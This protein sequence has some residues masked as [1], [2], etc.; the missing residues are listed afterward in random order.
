MGKRKTGSE[1]SSQIERQPRVLLKK[2]DEQCDFL[3]NN[4]AKFDQGDRHYAYQA[5][6]N[7]RAL[8]SPREPLPSFFIE[9]AKGLG[10]I[11]E[12]EGQPGGR[13]DPQNP[14]AP[15]FYMSSP[16]APGSV[17]PGSPFRKTVSFDEWW[18]ELILLMNVKGRPMQYLRGELILDAAQYDGVHIKSKVSEKFATLADENA[19]K[20]VQSGSSA[21]NVVQSVVVESGRQLLKV[22]S[23]SRGKM[24]SAVV[25][26]ELGEQPPGSR[27]AACP[28]GSGKRFKRCHGHLL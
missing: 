16:L 20:L 21:L 1:Y 13:I 17:S 12:F 9:I 2:L 8:V 5:A 11:T 6:G 22:I 10:V 15:M 26:Q 23:A 18:G 4:I 19:L 28:C 24:E 14:N 25:I 27:N 7:I 3:R